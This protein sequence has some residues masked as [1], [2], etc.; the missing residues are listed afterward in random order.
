M[1]RTWHVG[2]TARAQ[3]T[4]K[5]PEGSIRLCQ[6]EADGGGVQDEKEGRGVGIFAGFPLN[7]DKLP[8][9]KGLL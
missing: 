4:P 9:E 2:C 8:G 5:L 1:S 6:D 7:Q 3:W